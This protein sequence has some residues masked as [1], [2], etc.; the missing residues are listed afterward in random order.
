MTAD[1]EISRRALIGGALAATAAAG[2][3]L[4]AA[5]AG[6]DDPVIELRQYKIIRGRRDQF[7][8]LFDRQ[9][10]EPQE[11]LGMR[12]VGQF[13]DLDDPDRFTWIREFPAMS[14]RAAQL[15]QFYS[16]PVWLAH[17]A[18]A[19][20]M[21]DDNDNVLLLKPSEPGAGFGPIERRPGDLHE[22]DLIVATIHYLWK[23]PPEAFSPFF[24]TTARAVLKDAG[25][26]VLGSFVGEGRPNEFPRLP[27]RQGEKVFVWVA[28]VDGMGRYERAM[29]ALR[30]RAGAKRGGQW[31]MPDLE[32][33]PAQVLRLGG[34]P[35]SRL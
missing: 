4:P 10:V 21:L 22:R 11:M 29:T 33:R 34:T 27:V 14:G 8:A 24:E 3:P 35:R 28:R 15:G 30:G 25:V 6:G 9:F 19:N 31:L 32:E 12:I 20:P 26:G 7:I 1:M 13:R 5:V 2:A 23:V 16:G 17:R 18:E